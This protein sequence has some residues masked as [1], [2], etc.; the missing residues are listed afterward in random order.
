MLSKSRVLIRISL[1]NLIISTVQKLQNIV[2][3]EETTEQTVSE[4]KSGYN[5]NCDI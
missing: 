3:H 1:Y 2:G 5:I 4:T